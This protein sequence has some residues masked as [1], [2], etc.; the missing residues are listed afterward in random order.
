METTGIIIAA[1]IIGI[2][3]PLFIIRTGK[4]PK[5]YSCESYNAIYCGPVDIYPPH[6]HW[7][8]ND[9]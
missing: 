7:G 9:Y 6:K 8:D 1:V 5:D 4:R 3:L 2:I